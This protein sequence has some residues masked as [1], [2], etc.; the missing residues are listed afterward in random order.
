MNLSEN[1]YNDIINLIEYYLEENYTTF[2]DSVY[3]DGSSQAFN[4][5]VKVDNSIRRNKSNNLRKAY[6]EYK[7]A[8]KEDYNK[9]SIYQRYNH[10]SNVEKA[11]NNINKSREELKDAQDEVDLQRKHEKEAK[12]FEERYK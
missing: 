5:L 11:L 12:D 8:E 2:R 6:K 3:D 4:N 7:K 9:N 1:C 10:L